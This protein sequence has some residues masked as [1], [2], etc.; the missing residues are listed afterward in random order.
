MA[1]LY[2][3]KGRWWLAWLEN[4]ERHSRSTGLPLHEKEKAQALK[5]ELEREV[6]AR[7]DLGL[8]PSKRKT[9]RG[10]KLGWLDARRKAGVADVDHEVSRLLHARDLD[11]LDMVEVKPRHLRDLVVRLKA[12]GKLAP[13]TIRHVYFLLRQ[14]FRDAQVDE[15]VPSNPCVLPKGVLPGKKDK[16][17]AWRATAVF[18][19]EEVEAL[20]SDARIPEDR[21]TLYALLF[22]TGCRIG[23]LADRR[24]RD[25]DAAREPLGCLHVHTSFHT[26]RRVSKAP[27]TG[28]AREVP[29]H[30][31]LAKVLASWK[32]G[33]WARMM[34][35]PPGVEDLVIPTGFDSRGVGGRQRTSNHVRNKLLAD[36]ER[37]GLRARRT[38]DSRR[39]F[40]SLGLADGGRKEILRWV[41]HGPSGDVMDLYTTL[42]WAA[43]CGE[44]A[45]LNIRLRVSASPLLH[46][47]KAKG[48]D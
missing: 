29:V 34:G 22:L 18:T 8:L 33:G 11:A 43:L 42:P 44:V 28:V 23:E 48:D 17:P 10:Y 3:R 40:I 9:V 45:K 24:W 31:V 30:P 12:E 14:M 35:R 38:H 13:R 1:S 19:R 46:R 7:R 47:Q 15:V 21:R 6:K 26:K 5:V 37:V 2:P 20:I 25:Y 27:K 41:S 4:R 16:N 39:T 36:L 32:L